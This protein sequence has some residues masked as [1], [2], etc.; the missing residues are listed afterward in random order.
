MG[1]SGTSVL[2]TEANSIIEKTDG[3]YVI[4]T[5]TLVD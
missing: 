2:Y 1:G 3:T 4:P 5:E